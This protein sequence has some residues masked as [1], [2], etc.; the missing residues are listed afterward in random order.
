MALTKALDVV[1]DAEAVFGTKRCHRFSMFV[2]DNEIK[3]FFLEEDPG[4]L[5]VT[6]AEEM[7]KFLSA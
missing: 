2:E 7:I 6:S 4:K 3:A 1:L 5:T